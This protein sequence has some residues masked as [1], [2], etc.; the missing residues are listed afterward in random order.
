MLSLSLSVSP[1]D[2]QYMSFCPS[3]CASLYH[4]GVRRSGVYTIILSPGSPLPV[5]CDMETE[6]ETHTILYIVCIHTV[7]LYLCVMYLKVC[8]FICNV[9]IYL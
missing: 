6:G 4:N 1:S 7:N 8:V 2:G 5:Y 9:Y 3:D